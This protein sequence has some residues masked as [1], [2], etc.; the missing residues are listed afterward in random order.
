MRRLSPFLIFAAIALAAG[1]AGGLSS[2][3]SQTSPSA[4]VPAALKTM[5]LSR[6]HNGCGHEHQCAQA[7]VAVR[8]N[9]TAFN[10]AT[11]YSCHNVTEHAPAYAAPTSAPLTLSVWCLTLP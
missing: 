7:V 9:G 6:D 10:V 5:S 11:S 1:C 3:P 4:N 8:Y 2:I